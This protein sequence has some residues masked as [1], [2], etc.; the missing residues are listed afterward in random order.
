[1]EQS[2]DGSVAREVAITMRYTPFY[3]SLL[4]WQRVVNR[5]GSMAPD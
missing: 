1:M 3:S 4:L 2:P 5:L